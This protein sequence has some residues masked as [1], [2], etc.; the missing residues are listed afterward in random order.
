MQPLGF[1]KPAV[2][3]WSCEDDWTNDLRRTGVWRSLGDDDAVSLA[4]GNRVIQA[5][6]NHRIETIAEDLFDKVIEYLD[7]AGRNDDEV[8]VPQPDFI[9]RVWAFTQMGS[10]QVEHGR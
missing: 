9:G 5:G 8:V 1:F 4:V 10:A 7:G 6:G 2:D 3:E